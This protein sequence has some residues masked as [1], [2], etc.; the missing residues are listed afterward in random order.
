MK[1]LYALLS[2]VAATSAAAQVAEPNLFF[3]E[4]SKCDRSFFE[5]LDEHRSKLQNLAP[6]RSL[7][8]A[9]SFKVPSPEHRTNS[10]VMFANAQ[11]IEGLKV[12]G[13][14]DE[15]L[16]IPNG[17]SSY[18]W[19]YLIA[20]NVDE[21]AKK[22]HAL[23]WDPMRL[24]KDGPVYVRSEVWSYENPDAGWARSTTDSGVPKRG[25]VER[26]LLIEPYDGENSFIRFGCSIQGNITEP[27]LRSV[28]PDLR[29]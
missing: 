16:D 8:Q 5:R 20:S 26:V 18:S 4:L 27:L 28:R 17:M 9:A 7:G 19:G 1:L 6:M 22:L 11:I 3:K 24:R 23:I 29:E 21:S 2:L 12:I 10:R 14:F 25:T 13:Y 15:V